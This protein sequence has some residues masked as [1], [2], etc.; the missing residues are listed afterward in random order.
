MYIHIYIY[1]W[2]LYLY[3]Y[4]YL[5]LYLCLYLYLVAEWAGCDKGALFACFSPLDSCTVF[6]QLRKAGF[7]TAASP[8]ASKAREMEMT[9]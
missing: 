8:P 4:V 2:D 6:S 7:A 5:Y 3:L 9:S 1:L